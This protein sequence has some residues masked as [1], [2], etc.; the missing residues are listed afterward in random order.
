MKY[1]NEMYREATKEEV[2]NYH[3]IN[4]L[5]DSVGDEMMVE[6]WIETIGDYVFSY[7]KG[8][9]YNYNRVYR[10]AKRLN[11]TV[12]SLEDWYCID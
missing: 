4:A 2:A 5:F 7:G 8:R 3:H 11:V 9:K 10:I 1:T 12:R 6:R